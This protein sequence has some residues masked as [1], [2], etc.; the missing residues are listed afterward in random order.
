MNEIKIT[1]EVARDF[2]EWITRGPAICKR[3]DEFD[4]VHDQRC[5][6]HPDHDP[7]PWCNGCGA[8]TRSQCHCGPRAEND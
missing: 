8:R 7:T 2:A 6:L 5:P 4:E 3:C 1:A